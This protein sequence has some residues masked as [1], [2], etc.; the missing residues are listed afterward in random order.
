MVP[1]LAVLAT[2]GE[3]TCGLAMLVGIRVSLAGTASALLLF[4]FAT[5]MVLSG[6]SQFQY[7]VYLMSA[8]AWAL[9]TLDGADAAF[10][11]FPA[12]RPTP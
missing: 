2:I 4:V 7:S 3:S 10:A 9:A 5:A 1:A 8:T 11:P 6:L 12:R